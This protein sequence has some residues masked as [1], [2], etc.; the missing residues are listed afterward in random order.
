[1]SIAHPT[2]RPS[3]PRPTDSVALGMHRRWW[4]RLRLTLI[5]RWKSAELDRRLASGMSPWHSDELALRARRITRRRSR[6]QLAGGLSRAAHAAQE[7]SGFSSAVRPHPGE[8]LEAGAVLS[9]VAQRLRAPEPVAAHGVAMV[10]LLL[11]DAS[12][13]LYCPTARGALGRRLRAAAAAME[14]IDGAGRTA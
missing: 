9:A 7:V 5:V 10:Q 12:S 3:E 13:P 6:S 8:V 2:I 4:R 1:M 11:T 14:P